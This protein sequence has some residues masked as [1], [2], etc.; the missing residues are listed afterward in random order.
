MTRVKK[1]HH[2]RTQ[3]I[4]LLYFK[5]KIYDPSQ[6]M[7]HFRIQLIKLLYYKDK[8][9]DPSQKNASL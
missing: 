9:Y 2:F 1:M 8:I 3:F 7:H 5:D 6:K 4:K